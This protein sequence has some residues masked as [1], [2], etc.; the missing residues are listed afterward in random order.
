MQL[1]LLMRMRAEGGRRLGLSGRM[2][3]EKP[4]PP[5]FRLQMLNCYCYSFQQ[6][7]NRKASLTQTH[8]T[9]V[10]DSRLRGKRHVSIRQLKVASEFANE[11]VYSHLLSIFRHSRVADMRQR[12]EELRVI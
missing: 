4:D 6:H 3:Q 8:C 1:V 7:S 9:R 10:A 11:A 5:S 12:L 2:R